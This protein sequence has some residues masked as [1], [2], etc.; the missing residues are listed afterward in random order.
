MRSD[1]HPSLTRCCYPQK[2]REG[3]VYVSS[4]LGARS[5]FDSRSGALDFGAVPPPPF[6]SRRAA[7]CRPDSGD[8]GSRRVARLASRRVVSLGSRRWSGSGIYTIDYT[9]LHIVHSRIVWR[10][11]RA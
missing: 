9:S 7:S 10:S 11:R 1:H 6:G 5:C 2:S 8:V 3:R 4:A